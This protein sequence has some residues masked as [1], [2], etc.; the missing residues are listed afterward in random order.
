VSCPYERGSVKEGSDADHYKVTTTVNY[1]TISYLRGRAKPS[2]YPR[3][4]R[5]YPYEDRT[6][7]VNSVY[8][9][10]WKQESDGDFHLVLK[11]SAGRSMIAEVPYGGCVPSS[12]R[13]RAAIAGVRS[14][15]T[16]HVS[17]T[18]SWHYGKRLVDIRGIAMFDPPHGPTTSP[19]TGSNCI[20]SLRSISTEVVARTCPT[21]R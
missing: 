8:L 13:W 10:Q 5:L 14:T 2:T 19:P 21:P 12:S 20:P 1:T 16:G 18:R 6:W 4:N 3:N 7:Q 17:V 15:V 11:N 9:T